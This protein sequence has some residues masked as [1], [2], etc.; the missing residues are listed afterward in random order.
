MAWAPVRFGIHTRTVAPGQL[1][2]QDQSR[3][4]SRVVLFSSGVYF[5]QFP[6]STELKERYRYPPRIFVEYHPG[7]FK[8]DMTFIVAFA[9]SQDRR[10]LLNAVDQWDCDLRFNA[11]EVRLGSDLPVVRN[12]WEHVSL[13]RALT[14]IGL[15]LVYDTVDRTDVNSATF[16]AATGFV[17]KGTGPTPRFLRSCGFVRVGDLEFLQHGTGGHAFRLV[18]DGRLWKVM[19]SFFGGKVEAFVQFPGPCNER[20]TCAQGSTPLKS[21]NCDVSKQWTVSYPKVVF[22]VH[23]HVDLGNPTNIVPSVGVLNVHQTTEFKRIEIPK[24]A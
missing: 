12:R 8:D 18:H 10:R 4:E 19:L 21:P 3:S 17:R 13:V 6:D 14:K 23:L 9:E 2:H 16:A 11:H 22:P 5:R 15:N 20:W 7:Q 24:R 1:F